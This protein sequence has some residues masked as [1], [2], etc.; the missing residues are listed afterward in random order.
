MY[1]NTYEV[2]YAVRL[3]I[4]IPAGP[5][6]PGKKIF[7]QTLFDVSPDFAVQLFYAYTGP[8]VPLV[9]LAG[10][11]NNLIKYGLKGIEFSGNRYLEPGWMLDKTGMPG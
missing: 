5:A 1:L 9:K 2:R 8:G 7:F 6:A 11:Q 3:D 10:I 4:I